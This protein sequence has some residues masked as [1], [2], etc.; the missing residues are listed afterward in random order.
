MKKIMTGALLAM[1]ALSSF[2]LATD[3]NTSVK[4]CKH[5]DCKCAEKKDCG[6]KGKKNCDKKDENSTS[7][8]MHK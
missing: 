5:N 4:G 7:C 3:S 2:A 8:A 6:C 1:F